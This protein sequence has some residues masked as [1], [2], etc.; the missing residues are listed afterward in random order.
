M[1]TFVALSKHNAIS[2]PK[3]LVYLIRSDGVNKQKNLGRRAV[4]AMA[5]L[6]PDLISDVVHDVDTGSTSAICASACGKGHRLKIAV[7]TTR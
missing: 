3:P 7:C 6:C 5:E 1:P 4:Q 2:D